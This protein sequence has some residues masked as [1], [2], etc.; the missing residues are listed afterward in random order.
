M[1]AIVY[2]FT[3]SLVHEARSA[4]AAAGAPLNAQR[5]GPCDLFG[6]IAADC[7]W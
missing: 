1:I 5:H 7:G 6:C 4:T 2:E 3:E